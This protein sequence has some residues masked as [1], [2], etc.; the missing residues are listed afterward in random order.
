MAPRRPGYLSQFLWEALALTVVGAAAGVGLGLTIASIRPRSC[1]W[2][3][4][5]SGP[6]IAGGV[7]FALAV[8]IVFGFLPARRAAAMDPI[9]R[10][11]TNERTAMPRLRLIGMCLAMVLAAPARA[12]VLTLAEVER[13]A[14]ANDAASAS[15]A[16]T[17]A[18]AGESRSRPQRSPAGRQPQHGCQL[19][20]PGTPRRRDLGRQGSPFSFKAR[21]PSANQGHH[22][23]SGSEAWRRFKPI[24]SIWTHRQPYPGR[25]APSPSEPQRRGGDPRRERSRGGRGLPRLDRRLRSPG[26][27]RRHARAVRAQAQAVRG[28]IAERA[29]PSGEENAARQAEATVEIESLDAAGELERTR[30]P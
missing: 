21:K 9:E 3:R 2:P 12:A 1:E 6:G 22:Q 25:R 30:A 16:E 7:G 17:D 10:S 24:C 28:S 15:Q 23:W 4:V 11:A 13:C 27:H 5:I 8:G 26:N 19:G 18:V 20:A 29:D 14:V